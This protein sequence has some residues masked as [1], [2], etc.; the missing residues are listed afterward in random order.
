MNEN[1]KIVDGKK[2]TAAVV[3]INSSG[4][5]LGCKVTGKNT[6]DFPKGCVDDGECDIDAAFRELY[7]ETGIRVMAPETYGNI[8]DCG[9]HN[10][11]REKNIHIFLWRTESFP[12]LS[13]LE[14]VSCFERDGKMIPEVNGYKIIS[15]SE[16]N[17]FNR[18]L[19]DKFPLID[20]T[21]EAFDENR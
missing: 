8:I 10:H 16:R 6:Y 17:L 21:N 18:I 3:I 1:C 12:D 20:K 13:A 19:W 7:E 11:N 4:D 5:I 2:V 15:K 14:C 9:V